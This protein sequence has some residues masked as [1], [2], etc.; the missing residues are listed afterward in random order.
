MTGSIVVAHGPTP[1]QAALAFRRACERKMTDAIREVEGEV[2]RR[3]PFRTGHLRRSITS[4]VFVQ[5]GKIYGL[6]GTTTRYAPYL[7]MGT[8]LYGPRNRPIVPVRAQALR[9]PAGG[10]ASLFAGGRRRQ[11]SAGPGFRLSGAR[12]AGS[13]GASA[14][15][16]FARSVKGIHPRHFFRDSMQISEGRVRRHLAEIGPEWM[17]QLGARRA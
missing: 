13:A 5:A 2:R 3:A 12:R 6:V 4:R 1:D 16:V 17:K 10:S 11:G 8:G 14:R 7:E 9:F 15:Y